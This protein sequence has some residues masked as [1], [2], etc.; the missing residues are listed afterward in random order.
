MCFIL[1]GEFLSTFSDSLS[2]FLFFFFVVC[3]LSFLSRN[4]ASCVAFV[5]LVE[6]EGSK[7]KNKESL[8]VVTID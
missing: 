4:L 6:K 2:F 8:A 5:G 3:F 1:F 7:K